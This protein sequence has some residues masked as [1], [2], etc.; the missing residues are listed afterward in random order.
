MSTLAIA[1]RGDPHGHRE[2]TVPAVLA[3]LEQG[4]DLVEIDLALTRDG[5][6]VL[7]H[8]RTLTRLWA[9]D[10]PVADA[11]FAELR[12]NRHGRYEIPGF[13]QVMRLLVAGDGGLM[14][15]LPV[16]AAAEPTAEIVARYDAFDRTVFAGHLDSLRRVR[17][18]WPE[19]RIALSWNEPELPAAE[20][21]AELKPEFF[22]PQWTLLTREVVERMH[23]LALRVSTWTVDSPSN[24]ARMLEMGVDAVITNRLRHFLSLREEGE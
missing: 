22:N 6:V 11:D 19:A 24:M 10:V 3:A 15:D 23:E 2:N 16:P 18:R 14:A 12:R 21:L 1:H 13:E 4:A 9:R 8:D 7:L 20:L 17:K 5:T